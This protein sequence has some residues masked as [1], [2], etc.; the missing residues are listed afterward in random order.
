V[1]FPAARPWEV[2]QYGAAQAR[3]FWTYV[4][5]MCLPVNLSL[6]HEA[7][8]PAAAMDVASARFI[9]SALGLAALAGACVAGLKRH[10]EAGFAGLFSLLYLLPTSSVI[11]LTVVVNENR[12]YLSLLLFLWPLLLMLE[13]ARRRSPKIPALIA[14]A[15]V[16]CFAVG[17]H[18]RGQAFAGEVTAW[19][20]AV[21]KAPEM[22]QPHVNLGSAYLA[23][24]RS[25]E[26]ERSLEWAL[27]ID[28]CSAPA[29]T[30]LGN[31]AYG[32]GAWQDAEKDYERALDCDPA[33]V[34]AM[35]N[36]ADLLLERGREAQAVPLLWRSLA[37]YPTQSEVL[38]KLGLY[39]ARH[40]ADRRRGLELLL[41][42]AEFAPSAAEAEKWRRRY[43]SYG[44]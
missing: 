26:A 18:H 28:P 24:G 29:L 27:R 7:W 15:I 6:E 33:S 14:A 34:P 31:I 16:I 1:L 19:R 4:R 2:W 17:A 22:S 42:A 25:T 44:G 38:G 39:Y 3:A 5:L 23:Y 37:L 12:P 41:K 11:P 40:D 35:L 30:D 32:R 8:M 9:L 21:R 10:P 13:A 20:D 36:L 43:E